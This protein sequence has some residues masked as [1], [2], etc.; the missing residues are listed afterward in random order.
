MV[1]VSGLSVTGDLVLDALADNDV[2]HTV[3][4]TGAG[5]RAFCVDSEIAE[6]QTLMALGKIALQHEMFDRFD[7]FAKPTAAAI[8]GLAFGGGLEIGVCSDLLVAD[9]TTRFALPEIKLGVVLGSGGPVRVTRRVDAGRAKELMFLGEPI[10]AV[11]ARALAL[12]KQAID[13]S[14]DTNE[15]GT[16][17]QTLPLSDGC[18]SS[19]E[20]TEGVEAFLANETPRF[21]ASGDAP[22]KRL[23]L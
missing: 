16:I 14:F 23:I 9:E 13:L 8:N 19:A 6:F 17:R 4:V 5:T 2:M 11:T 7:D 15:K 10:V 20:A 18:F 22:Q 3:V 21:A 1:D 12:R